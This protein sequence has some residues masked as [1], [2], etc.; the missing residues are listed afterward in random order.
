MK[1][2]VYREYRA[3]HFQ[4]IKAATCGSDLIAFT[5]KEKRIIVT[6]AVGRMHERLC[7]SNVFERAFTSTGTFMP[8]DHLVRDSD[9]RCVTSR[10]APIEETQVKLQHMNEYKYSEQV[11]SKAVHDA[12]DQI[13]KEKAAAEAKEQ[14]ALAKHDAHIEAEKVRQQPYT[15]LAYVIRSELTARIFGNISEDLNA[16]HCE[17]GLERFIIGGSWASAEIVKA[18][19]E[20]SKTTDELEDFEPFELIANDIDIYHGPFC[21]E[22]APFHVDL[23]G[24]EKAFNRSL[25]KELNT[26][27]CFSWSC[28]GFLANNDINITASC[29]EIDFSKD[30]CFTIH[31]SPCFWEFVFGDAKNRTIQVV[32]TFEWDKYNATTC[33]RLAFKAF[34]M[35]Q[36]N[37]NMGNLNPAVGTFANSQKEKLDKMKTWDKYPFHPFDCRKKKNHFVFEAKHDK[38]PCVECKTGRVN[39]QCSNKMC[40]KCCIQYSLSQSTKC[41]SRDHFKATSAKQQESTEPETTIETN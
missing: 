9:G 20:L 15:D 38:V 13:A 28:S 27:K 31:A 10:P 1:E 29:F 18:I 3:A 16:I 6:R 37:F 2:A 40:K 12:I 19:S 32:D 11:A 21:D 14:M 7:N 41:K 22:N 4:R 8:I 17:T 5:P 36:F 23:H 34:E 26:V 24:I 33:I 25:L 39:K 35:T 30:E